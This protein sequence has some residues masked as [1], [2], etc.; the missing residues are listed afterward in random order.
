MLQMTNLSQLHTFQHQY[1]DEIKSIQYHEASRK[2]MTA[3]SKVIKVYDKDTGSLFTT[4][5]PKNKIND[6]EVC[7][8]TGLMIVA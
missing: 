3:D 2:I 8:N 7:G 5:E 4:I 1:R 6:F